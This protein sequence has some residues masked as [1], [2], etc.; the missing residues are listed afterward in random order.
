MSWVPKPHNGEEELHAQVDRCFSTMDC[1]Q[2]PQVY[3]DQYQYAVCTCR[4]EDYLSPDL[5]SWAW[6]H[7]MLEDFEP[8]THTAFQ[9][10]KLKQAKAVGVTS[11]QQIA[12]DHYKE[13]KDM[14]GTS[15][16]SQVG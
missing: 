10:S 8:L 13:W 3:C 11:L 5:L 2:W 4:K 12:S 6:Y 16:T 1:F 14:R 7:P 15:K 9:V